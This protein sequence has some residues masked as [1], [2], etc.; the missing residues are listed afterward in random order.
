M[1]IPFESLR[2]AQCRRFKESRGAGFTLVEVVLA[3]AIIAFAL[4]AIL[5]LV[6]L[7]V[8]GTK[9]ADL[10]ARLALINRRVV[11]EF[12]SQPFLVVTGSFAVHP[13]NTSYYDLYGTPLTDC[14]GNPIAANTNAKY[15]QC[16][17]TNSKLVSPAPILS[18]TDNTA[19]IQNAAM[20]QVKIRWP[21]PQ[22]TGTDTTVTSIVNYR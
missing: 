4:T 14:Y 7:A 12:Q 8:Q 15:F 13:T 16:D 22:L 9:D 17:V 1:H 6:G 20:M 18:G 2:G 19:L 5:G 11:S 10:Y 21:W 3:I